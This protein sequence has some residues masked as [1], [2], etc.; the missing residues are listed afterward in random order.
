[1]CVCVCVYVSVF[2]VC[3]LIMYTQMDG[4]KM[5][6][7]YSLREPGLVCAVQGE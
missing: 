1:M 2:G 6:A 7:T 4:L 3:V 5:K